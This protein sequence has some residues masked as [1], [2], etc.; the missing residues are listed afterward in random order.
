MLTAYDYTGALLVDRAESTSS[1]IGD[2]LGMVIMGL[3]SA[4][5]VTM[6]EM[7]HHCRAVAQGQNMP[8]SGDLPFLSL[9]G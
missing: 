3:E 2:S 9:S 8:I 6:E 5:P 7:L 1:L 4:V